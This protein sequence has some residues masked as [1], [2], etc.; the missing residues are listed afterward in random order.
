MSYL[1]LA[2]KWRPMRFDEVVAQ[3][4]VT[5]TLENAIRQ[6]RLASAYLFAGPRGVGKTTTARILAKAVNCVQ[7]PTVTP[8]NQCPNCVEI[9]ES[10]SLDVFEIDGAS[11]LGIDEVRN[12]RDN[13]RY[14]PAR[15]K[16]R[17][18]IIDEVH[19]LTTEAFNALLK[20]LEEPPRHV[21]FMFATTEPQK[22]P[23]TILSRCQRFDFRRIP[24]AEITEQL[25]RI[26]QAEAIDIDAESRRLIATKAD[27]SLRDGLS[28]LDQVI[29]FC[30]EK[31]RVQD[32]W[33]L[34]GIIPQDLFFEV[35]D[36][37]R[38][39]DVP[40]GFELADRVM[41]QGYDVSEF[42]AGL[43]EHF[44][45]FLLVKNTLPERANDSALLEVSE[46]HAQRYR[47]EA[48]DFLDEDLLRLI[49]I[50]TESEYQIKRSPTPKVRLEM[51][52]VKMIKLDSSVQLGQLL[53]RLED[54]KKNIDREAAVAST[55]Q[56]GSP[57]AQPVLEVHDPVTKVSRPEPS[58]TERSKPDLSPSAEAAVT[59]EV[60]RE[61]WGMI[62]EEVKRRKIA[63]GSFLNEGY[64]SRLED[65]VLE[66]AFGRD[67]GFH[68]NSI[69]RSKG[70]I[71]DVLKS[72]LGVSWRIQCKKVEASV[73]QPAVPTKPN[74]PAAGGRF[75]V[76]LEKYPGVRNIVELFDAELI[77]G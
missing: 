44:R 25:K 68:I 3:R 52:L 21:M 54:L 19:M 16:A 23:P 57:V 12:L 11:N 62:V 24:T 48:K 41:A 40:G 58:P 34:L 50:A 8:C 49:H 18:Y 63:L 67:N 64:P 20:I 56:G 43:A 42:F 7:G 6:N 51:A 36:L 37:I 22:V 9:T 39:R 30:G 1:V 60:V 5:L 46:V 72:V 17:I 29:A 73:N 32:V 35:S 45:N 53:D 28:I 66:I 31:V 33:S 26:C 59:I 70:V 77:G 65:G 2:R 55:R 27:G 14:S 76:F 74:Q 61:K 4:H 69:N 10:R 13:I 71:Q 75:E 38:K 15:G 47:A